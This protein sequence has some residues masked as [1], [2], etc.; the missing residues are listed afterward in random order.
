MSEG[1]DKSEK[2]TPRRLQQAREDGQVAKSQDL[3]GALMLGGF[4]A[5]LSWFGVYATSVLRGLMHTILSHP[6]QAVGTTAGALA[7]IGSSGQVV[8]TLLGPLFIALM[9]VAAGA[10]LMQV[11]FVLS[12]KA[13][14]PKLEKINPINGAKRFFSMRSW[15]EAGKGILKMSAMGVI[16]TAIVQKHL[17][18]A[19]LLNQLPLP[20]A[21]AH[22]NSWMMELGFW[23]VG[24]YL[25]IGVAD[26]KYQAFE[27]EKRLRMSKQDI[28]DEHKN[29]EGDPH[30]KGKL[31]QMGAALIKKK[32]LAKVPTADVVI[33]NPT[34]YAIAIRYDPDVAPAPHVVAK[35]IDNFA[36][37]IKEVAK[38][39][40]VSIVENR[41]L[42]RSLYAS[43]E[44]GQMIPPDLFVA[45][46]EVL[47]LV[48]AKRKGRPKMGGHSQAKPPPFLKS[49]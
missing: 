31:R 20:V 14:Q 4:M 48:Y 3:T 21:A 7:V 12:P 24:V 29:L 10:N 13:L 26:W 33:V 42:A 15:V 44:Y 18:E 22:L 37:K 8:L 40:G 1:S 16:G 41:S 47:A 11:G 9:G 32:Q 38:E 36:L 46:A 5:I 25:A 30:V 2:P 6:N 27:H 17:P 43:V 39:N 34:H 23:L 19:W 35:G 45:V 49:P 28:K